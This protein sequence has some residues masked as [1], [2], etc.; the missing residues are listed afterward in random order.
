[1]HPDGTKISKCKNPE[2]SVLTDNEWTSLTHTEQKH[3]RA[4]TLAARTAPLTHEERG[5]ARVADTG[6]LLARAIPALRAVVMRD[7]PPP[8]LLLDA[9]PNPLR[10]CH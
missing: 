9:P 8:C 2:G 6:E 1:V 7:L 5:E 10:A 3:W 4:A